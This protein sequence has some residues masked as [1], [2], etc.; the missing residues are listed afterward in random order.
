MK[1]SGLIM[2]M[3]KIGVQRDTCTPVFVFSQEAEVGSNSG[4]CLQ[5]DG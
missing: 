2:K 3:T 1:I 4:V 5:T